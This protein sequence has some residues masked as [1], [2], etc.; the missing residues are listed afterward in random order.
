MCI[1]VYEEIKK[2]EFFRHENHM[3]KDVTFFLPKSVL[4]VYLIENIMFDDF[5]RFVFDPGGWVNRNFHNK[6]FVFFL[7]IQVFLEVGLFSFY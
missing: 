5:F 1:L 7:G 6:R 2:D 3:L 4:S